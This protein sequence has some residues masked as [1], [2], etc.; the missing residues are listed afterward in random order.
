MKIE[1][2]SV[3]PDLAAQWLATNT[4][5]NRR[6]SKTTV[7]RYAQDMIRDQWL[8]TGEALKFD[9]TGRL[10]DGQHRL[11]AVVASKKTVQM[12]IIRDL[13]EETILVIDTGKSRSAGDALKIAGQNGYSNAMAALARKIIVFN[14]GSNP[15]RGDKGRGL[16]LNGQTV[17]N[18]QIIEYCTENDLTEHVKFGWN[19]KSIGVTDAL[20]FGEYAF[21][22]WYF[23]LVDSQAAEIFLRK[24]ATL[25]NV[26]MQSPIR[27]L[28]NKLT[29]SITRLDGKM[30]MHA[31]ITAWN[32]WRKGEKLTLIHVGRIAADEP[33][34]IAV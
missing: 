3:T 21:F 20:N 13:P 7:N 9:T 31:V 17:T 18:R 11:S 8:I 30:K 34:P 29:R 10:I 26:D 12:Y 23:G 19:M 15:I 28:L 6:I 24:L 5:N 33:I 16:R 25:E 27:A 4:E 14:G 2:I 22:H 32:A 1:L